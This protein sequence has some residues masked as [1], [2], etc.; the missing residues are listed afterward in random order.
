MT[1]GIEWIHEALHGQGVAFQ[2]VALKDAE[3][4]DL[5][6]MP[7][8]EPGTVMDPPTC[9]AIVAASGGT[10]RLPDLARLGTCGGWAF[11]FETGEGIFRYNRSHLRHLW[12]GRTYVHISDTAMD[13]P[14]VVAVVDGKWDWQYFDGE[15][16]EQVRA[17]HPLTARMT[18]EIGLG[19]SKPD[20]GYP[21]DP[22]EWGLYVPAMADVYRLF[23]EH[24]R[25][26]LP[27]RTIG[28]PYY[29]NNELYG[30]FTAPRTLP[31]GQP[32]PK[33]DDIRR[34]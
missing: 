30:A 2:L 7:G 26:A 23:G 32:N 3:V 16:H 24:Y 4:G 13:P 5:A 33:Y 31:D 1:D 21:D 22:D 10:V 34:P 8:A 29:K 12:E 19:S 20:P 11:A 17:D 9:N 15:V 14:M 28:D 27:R 25:L 6:M 18:V